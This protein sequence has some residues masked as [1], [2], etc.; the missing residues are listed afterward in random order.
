M[1]QALP[2]TLTFEAFLD[3]YPDGQGRY[4][5]IDGIV[6]EMPPTGDREEVGAFIARKLNVEIDRLGQP[7]F[8]PRTYIVRPPVL[9]SG[10]QPDVLVV[11]RPSL[12]QEPL[13]KKSSVIT[14]GDSIL[15]AQ[16]A[17]LPGDFSD[18]ALVAISERLGIAAIATLDKD[19]DIYRRYRKRP[20]GYDVA[21]S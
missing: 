17:D 2:E 1:V 4:E 5:L 3:W 20:L 14:R 15:N 8:I 16:Y 10:Y 12:D 6:A 18:L 11:N 19:F 21:R 9:A 13:W 7:W